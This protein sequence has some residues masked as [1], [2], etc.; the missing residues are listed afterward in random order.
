M[1]LD[2]GIALVAFLVGAACSPGGDTLTATWHGSAELHDSVWVVTNP[3]TPLF[4]STLV[5]LTPQWAVE[6]T[7]DSVVSWVAP[8]HVR[9]LHGVAYVLDMPAFRIAAFDTLGQRVVAFGREGAG[10]GEMKAPTDLFV[11]NDAVG[12]GDGRLGRAMFYDESGHYL[13]SVP[14]PQMSAVWPAGDSAILVRHFQPGEPGWQLVNAD[15]ARELGP[16]SERGAPYAQSGAGCWG[17]GAGSTVVLVSCKSPSLLI[18]SPS[19]HLMRAVSI[20]RPEQR[21]TDAQLSHLK[22][23]MNERLSKM[24]MKPD[25]R[26]GMIEM[27]LK[28]NTMR[29]D[30]RGIAVD[31]AAGLIAIWDQIG[32]G[33]GGGNASFDVLSLS[34]VYLAH[35]VLPRPLTAFDLDGGRLVTLSEDSLTGTVTLR[36][37]R[38]DLPEAWR[39]VAAAADTVMKTD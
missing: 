2:R 12:V 39:A 17:D 14:I 27:A 6:L 38:I 3:D 31:S 19:M 23:F 11:M 9:L 13:R 22:A 34:G 26:A 18:F 4:D 20:E 7:P 29:K 5:S 28:E 16:M 35:L 8:G 37:A 32:D 33:Y 1:R 21:A 36:S 30:V 25:A 10:P 15:S 24:P